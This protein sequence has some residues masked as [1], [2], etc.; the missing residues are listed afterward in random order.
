MQYDCDVGSG[1]VI[2]RSNSY[3]YYATTGLLQTKTDGRGVTCTHY[4][5]AFLRPASNVYSGSLPE[6]NMTT[7][8]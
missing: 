2:T 1:G 5:D 4:F 3:A 6:Q 8:V 7:V